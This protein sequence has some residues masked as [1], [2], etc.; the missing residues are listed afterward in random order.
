MSGK[1]RER[2]VEEV[3]CCTVQRSAGPLF[4]G[5]CCCLVSEA[6]SPARPP[7]GLP[8]RLPACLSR[9]AL[10]S[11]KSAGTVVA[12]NI[13]FNMPRAGLNWDDGFGGGNSVEGNLGFNTCR[14]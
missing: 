3:Q 6:L 11:F 5:A 7:V 14:C 12:G 4:V 2:A 8:A 9:L 10:H 13:F 1:E